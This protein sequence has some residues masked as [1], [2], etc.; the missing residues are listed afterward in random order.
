MDVEHHAF[1]VIDGQG[2]RELIQL[3]DDAGLEHSGS[4]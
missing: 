2:L 4:S 3:S 1:D